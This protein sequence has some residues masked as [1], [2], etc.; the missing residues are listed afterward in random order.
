MDH[1]FDRL[2][3]RASSLQSSLDKFLPMSLR[4]RQLR[5]HHLAKSSSLPTVTDGQP[6]QGSPLPRSESSSLSERLRPKLL[7][8]VEFGAQSIQVTEKC[9]VSYM[10]LHVHVHGTFQVFLVQIWVKLLLALILS[11]STHFTVWK[12]KVFIYVMNTFYNHLDI[13]WLKCVMTDIFCPLLIHSAFHSVT[14]GYYILQSWAITFCHQGI[15]HFVVNGF[16]ILSSCI[17]HPVII[18]YYIH[19]ACTCSLK[20]Y[21]HTGRCKCQEGNICT[22]FD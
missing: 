3:R 5:N 17:W 11:T 18:G 7:R 8:W 21:L 12:S 20:T 13:P 14:I 6:S 19:A 4:T 9:P 15:W 1:M 2:Q 10:V 16:D 22:A